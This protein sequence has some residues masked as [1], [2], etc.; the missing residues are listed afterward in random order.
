MHSALG[1]WQ[2]SSFEKNFFWILPYEEKGST[3]EADLVYRF[4]PRKKIA[5]RVFVFLWRQVSIL[6]V[7]SA[8]HHRDAHDMTFL[9][10][11]M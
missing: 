8:L 3:W 6:F 10:S 5:Y 11:F 2:Q 9:F 4:T 1:F 7:V